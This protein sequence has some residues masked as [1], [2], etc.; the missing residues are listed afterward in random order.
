MRE[1]KYCPLCREPLV[2]R[3]VDE[4]KRLACASSSCDYVFWDNPTPVVAAIVEYRGKIIFARNKAWPKNMFGLVTGFLEKDEWPDEGVLREVKEELGLDGEISEFVG[5]Y[6]FSMM[7]QL[8]IAYFVTARGDLVLGEELA[9][10]KAVTREEVKPW[11]FGTGLA[12]ADWLK[13]Q[14]NP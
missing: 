8:I 3:Q 12:V 11:H 5:L 9:E 14:K 13:K 2:P 10:I 7:N 1:M 4:K 6:P